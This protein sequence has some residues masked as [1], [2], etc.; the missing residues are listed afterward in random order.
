MRRLAFPL[1]VQ[2]SLGPLLLLIAPAAQAIPSITRDA[3][4][5]LAKSG[6][7]SPY[8]WAGTCWNPQDRSWKG[9]DCSG[10]VTKC[11]QIPKT[12]KVTDCGPHYFTTW[13][14]KSK[15]THWK[16]ISRGDLLRGDALNYNL[17]SKGHIVLYEKGDKWGSATVY[18]ARGSAYGVVHRVRN[19]ASKYAAKRRNSITAPPPKAPQ[20]SV[21]A[22]VEGISGQGRDFCELAGSAKIFDWK[23]G[24]QTTIRVLVHNS[25]DGPAEGVTLGV[26][27]E[28]AFIEVKHW[29]LLTNAGA[30]SFVT[31]T[32][33]GLQSIPHDDPGAS[34]NLELGT[35]AAGERK[36]VDLTVRATHYSGPNPGVAALRAWIVAIKDRYAKATYDAPPTQNSGQTQNGGE[37]R[38]A[39]VTD[40]FDEETC[41]GHDNDCDG[42]RDEG[43]VCG[44]APAP[45]LGVTST[46]DHGPVLR[47]D[48]G[49]ESPVKP[50][51][52]GSGALEGGCALVPG[53]AGPG[54]LVPLV[55]LLALLLI[56]YR[57][58]TER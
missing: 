40:V 54:A 29:T 30:G 36:R 27:A 4:I 56:R 21:E 35:L 33:D 42:E 25:G 9:P 1:L 6:V 39:V 52:L 22:T 15:S 26:A 19:V 31:D 50:P 3:I 23:V 24:Q 53:G 2:L 47:L 37:L 38:A 12:S 16:T 14:Y 55:L 44:A 48:S 46:A 13:A 51:A 28:A 5:D 10:Y 41:D 43:D 18:E 7:G 8:V 49:T 57:R 58:E 32:Q 34:F 11:W 20:V 45:D 17:N